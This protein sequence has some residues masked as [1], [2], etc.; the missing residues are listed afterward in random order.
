MS[1]SIHYWR[2]GAREDAGFLII[3]N[4]SELPAYK[5]RLEAS[6]YTVIDAPVKRPFEAMPAKSP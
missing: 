6:G 3:T 5:A 1:C 2:P 4:E